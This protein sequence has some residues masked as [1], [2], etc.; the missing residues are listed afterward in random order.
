MEIDLLKNYPKAKRDLSARLES[1]SEEV[2][3]IAKAQSKNYS[4]GF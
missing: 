1:K 2:R 3:E 4:P